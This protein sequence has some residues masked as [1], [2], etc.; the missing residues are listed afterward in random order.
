MKP[1]YG[2]C[3]LCGGPIVQGQFW[4]LTGNMSRVHENVDH[5]IQ[6]LNIGRGYVVSPD[7]GRRNHI[8]NLPRDD[9]RLYA[10]FPAQSRER[11][12]RMAREG[13]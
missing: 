10:K 12:E 11:D 4:T 7:T 5:C 8:A 3:Q 9:Q 1:Q 6:K 2:Y 13:R